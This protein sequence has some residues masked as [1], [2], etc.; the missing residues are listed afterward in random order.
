MSELL[1]LDHTIHWIDSNTL[2]AESCAR[3]QRAQAVAVDTEFIRRRTY[4]PIPAL[5][6]VYDGE[7]IGVIDPLAISDWTPLSRV[8]LAPGVIKVLHSCSEDLEVFWRLLGQMPVPVFDTQIAAGLCG[9]RPSMGYNNLVSALCA[10]ELPKDQTNSNWLARP[11]S[12]VQLRYAACDVYYLYA[13]YQQLK[14][15][16]AELGRENWIVQD[17]LAMGRGLSTL[18]PP[19]ACYLRL[20]GVWRLSPQELAVARA[21]CAWREQQVRERDLPRSWFIKDNV[22]ISLARRQPGTQQELSRTDELPPSVIRKQ[23]E[24]LLQ[25]I[26]ESGEVPSSDWPAALPKPNS[27][28]ARPVIARLENAVA[29]LAG[30]LSLAPELLMSKKQMGVCAAQLIA[31]GEAALPGDISPWRAELLAPLLQGMNSA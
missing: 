14:L 24:T 11:L 10:L 1:G 20:K 25:I 22:I 16:A 3:W 13:I 12:G 21:L 7:F 18:V 2:L 31:T 4:Y 8:M 27:P 26:A 6:Q 5:I 19:E 15:R 30:D 9:L 28:A 23:G 29:V 17:S